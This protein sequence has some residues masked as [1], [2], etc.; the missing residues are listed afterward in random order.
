MPVKYQ[1]TGSDLVCRR[2]PE[3]TKMW[4]E[5]KLDWDAIEAQAPTDLTESSGKGCVMN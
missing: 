2:F 4:Q 1:E 3:C 5:E